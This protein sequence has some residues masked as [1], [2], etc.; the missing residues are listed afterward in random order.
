MQMRASIARALVTA[1]DLLLMDE[2]FGALDE[3]TRQRLDGELLALWAG[4]G[5]TVV[6][7]TH[8]IDEA[9]FLSTRVVVMGARPGR[10][11]AEV[12]ID[13][14]YPRT[15]AF[16]HSADV[17]RAL[18]A[19]V[20]LRRGGGRGCRRPALGGAG[21]MSRDEPRW[22]RWGAPLAV[23]LVALG[24]WQALVVAC[25]VPAYLV[26]SPL[27]V[28]RTLVADR[29]LLFDS[30]GVTARHRA[31]RAGDRH[32]CCGVAVALLFVQ[33][34][35]IEAS[36]FPYAV[37]LQVTPIV[38]IAPLIIIWVEGHAAPRWCC[39]RRSSRS[40]RSSPTRRSGCAASTRACSTCS[41]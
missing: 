17:R 29:A 27:A 33:S 4:R 13:E 6:F 36:L 18:A 39:A 40:S 16:R 32:R 41:G 1:P 14:P 24:L 19:A 34:R 12:A 30:L 3:F 15:D 37:L 35:W 22:L 20:G 7:V 25:D 10:V 21:G 38:A 11:L 2:P 5:L 28:A 31:R 23:A 26:P 9:V 8:S